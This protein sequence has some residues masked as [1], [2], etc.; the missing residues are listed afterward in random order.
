MIWTWFGQNQVTIPLLVFKILPKFHDKV[1][2]QFL[3]EVQISPVWKQK[4]ESL[5]NVTLTFFQV[6]IH[7]VSHA[8]VICHVTQRG[9]RLQLT[10]ARK[11]AY[12]EVIEKFFRLIRITDSPSTDMTT[13]AEDHVITYRTN[14]KI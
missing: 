6:A 10:L 5:K 12:I 3:E 13:S 14:V 2:N 1:I 4:C 9:T 11:K 7:L 8:A